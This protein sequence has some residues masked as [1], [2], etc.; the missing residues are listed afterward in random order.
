M[1]FILSKRKLYV[2]AKII[3]S[4]N[5]STLQNHFG[6]MSMTFNLAISEFV[7]CCNMTNDEV[8]GE[9]WARYALSNRPNMKTTSDALYL[10]IAY[11]DSLLA[12]AYYEPAIK[13]LGEISEDIQVDNPSIVTMVALRIC[14]AYRRQDGEGFQ[15]TKVTSYNSSLSRVVGS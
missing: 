12:A 11:A 13:E 1:G 2:P 3:L 9:R 4:S 6:R 14:K 5:L 8:E 7:K 15:S 10:R